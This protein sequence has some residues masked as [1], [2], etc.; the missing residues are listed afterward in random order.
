M[1]DDKKYYG[2]MKAISNI[3]KNI[4]QAG[5]A[6]ESLEV[7]LNP[8]WDDIAAVEKAYNEEF[9]YQLHNKLAP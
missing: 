2:A 8:I 9:A 6:D 4:V 5:L 7:V 3:K 1:I